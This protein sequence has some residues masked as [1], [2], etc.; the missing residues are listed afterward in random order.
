MIRTYL[1]P[2]HV[3]E[4]ERRLLLEAFDS[5]WL[6]TLGPQVDA[7]EREMCERTGALHAVALA[8]GTAAIHLALIALGVGPDDEVITPSLTF[9][10]SANPITY[11]GARPVF[12]D[13]EPATWNLDPDLLAEEVHAM[14]RRG[15][16][17]K[18][19]IAVDLYGQ[20]ADYERIL[21]VCDAHGIP[22]I[23]DAAEAL[24]ATYRGKQAGTFGAAAALSFNGNK[25]I[26]TSGGG[27]LLSPSAEI[28]KQSR[29]LALQ[30]REPV[31]HYEHRQIGYNY[32]LSN[33]LAAMGRAQLQKLDDRIAT[34]RGHREYYQSRLAGTPG[35]DFMPLSPKGEWNGWL[36]VLTIDPAKFG[37]DREELRLGLLKEGIESRPAWKPMH[38]QPVFEGYRM[39]GGAVSA[40][41]FER[42]LCLPSGSNL[43][44]AERER[45]CDVILAHHK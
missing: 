41:V 25:I 33:I 32:R 2:P 29:H 31:I 7:F 21:A 10:A 5:N 44:P 14:L 17:P 42:G 12:V 27:M 39:V 20:C 28:A 6:G 34:R 36:T 43:P 18:A 11:L 45:I 9:A 24:G 35:I 15:R 19:V 30:A 37:C 22:L 1:S 4:D 8:S 38:L 23:E 3:G 26:T 40:G 13:S 16:P